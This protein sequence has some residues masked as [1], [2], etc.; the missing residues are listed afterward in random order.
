[1]VE[2]AEQ[3]VR[4]AWMTVPLFDESGRNRAAAVRTWR[5]VAFQKSR[6]APSL[7]PRAD[8]PR[9]I[10]AAAPAEVAGQTRSSWGGGVGGRKKGICFIVR[11]FN[12]YF[13]RD[14]AVSKSPRSCFPPPIVLAHHER[15]TLR[16][17]H[18]VLRASGNKRFPFCSG[19]AKMPRNGNLHYIVLH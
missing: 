9:K 17:H 16:Q 18:V 13:I 4:N 19:L 7:F 8:P 5:A 2:D 6:R 11:F 3:N 10:C 12:D 15:E 1:M 14:V